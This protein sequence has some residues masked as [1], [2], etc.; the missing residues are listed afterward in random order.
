MDLDI[1]I[2]LALGL[3]AIWTL[4]YK[5]TEIIALGHKDFSAKLESTTRFLKDFYPLDKK[6]K[7]EG[8]RAAQELARLDYVDHDF[9]T[10][11]I[12]LHEKRLINFDQL[13]SH[14]KRGRK[15]IIYTPEENLSAKN[16]KLKIKEGRTIKMQVFI[17]IAQYIIFAFLFIVPLVFSSF[18]VNNLEAKLTFFSYIIAGIY[19]F[20]CLSLSLINLFDSGN[21]HDAESF[22]DQI[23]SAEMKMNDINRNL[24][25]NNTEN[26]EINILDEFQEINCIKEKIPQ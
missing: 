9:V 17:F 3:V 8:D 4:Y 11:L 21:I 20:G 14:Y 15:F 1:T 19:L 16:F 26:S 2:K 25:E 23:N 7:L 22:L 24:I 6:S 12:K 5:R 10:Y 13:L 18:F